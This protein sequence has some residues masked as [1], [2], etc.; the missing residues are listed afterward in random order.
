MA[1]TIAC[2]LIQL[3]ESPWF[4]GQWDKSHLYFFFTDQGGLDLE[5]PFLDASF[6]HF[7][8]GAEP[9]DPD[10]LHPNPG[11]LRLGVLLLEIHKW[12]PIE[13]LRLEADLVN[14]APTVNTDM[15]VANRALR[16]LDD[17]FETYQGAVRACL[18]P[19]WVP[20]G[21]RLSLEDEDTWQAMYR[22]VVEPLTFETRLA[23][24]SL[25]E[26]RIMWLLPA[27]GD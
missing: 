7:P 24:A 15:H 25:E 22:D 4:S 2:S 5:H 16:S 11:I 14:G 6:E 17:C 20:A 10:F 23:G 3:H 26:L 21:S 8:V 18:Q 1:K 13:A 19:D 27:F 12:Q 9:S